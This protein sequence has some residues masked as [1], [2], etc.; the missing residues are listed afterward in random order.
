MSKSFKAWKIFVIAFVCMGILF[1]L[2]LMVTG[3]D[4]NPV[5]ENV[6]DDPEQEEI[7]S[8]EYSNLQSYFS[9]FDETSDTDKGER[10]W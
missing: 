9:E 6:E 3:C 1:P 5:T 8:E 10:K 7:S 2:S 4:A